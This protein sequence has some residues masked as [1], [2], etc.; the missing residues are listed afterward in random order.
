LSPDAIT[1]AERRH[2]LAVVTIALGI[3]SLIHGLSLPML[4]LVLEREGVDKTLIGLNAT[5][6]FVAVFA[7]APF[8]PRL[9]RNFGPAAMMFWSV[10]ASA[11]VFLALP[12]YVNVHVWFVLRL[13]L[14]IALSFLWIAGEAWVS[15][16][17]E[18]RTRGRTV[19]IYGAVTAAGFALGP[20]ALAAVGS[21]GWR[22]FLLAASVMAIAAIPLALARKSGPRLGGRPSGR[23]WRYVVLAPVSMWMYF[24][25]SAAE[26]ALLTF[27]P[28]YGI[29]A[30]LEERIAIALLTAMAIGAIASQFPVGWM[31]DRLNGMMLTGIGAVLL[32]GV[33]VLLPE[34][35][36]RTPWNA[37][38]LLGLGALLGGFYTLSL[39]FLGRRFKGADLGPAVT[40]RSIMFCLGAMAGPPVDGAAIELLGPDGMAWMLAFLF[41]LV[42]PLPV[43]GFARRWNA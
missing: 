36:G 11:L 6:Q 40:A 29:Q 34:S 30:G 42:M 23:F 5:A 41:L 38:L 37:V 12:V 7:A 24:A 22:P 19:A 28:I 9:M 13:L 33:C 31:A 21:E 15:H 17:A 43:I 3:V 27:L 26:A 8:V 18:E 16:L 4:S 14:G 2:A 1:A 10:L 39:V 20:L 32:T 35:I 25:F